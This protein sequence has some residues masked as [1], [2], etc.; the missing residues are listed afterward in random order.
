MVRYGDMQV[1]SLPL[2]G[3]VD[4]IAP[5][6]KVVVNRAVE[7]ENFRLTKDGSRIQKR[8]GLTEEVTNFAVDLFGYTT[9]LNA[10]DTF[11]ELAVLET[12]VNRKVGAGAWGQIY[13]FVVGGTPTNIAHPVIPIEIQGKEFVITEIDSRMVHYD[14]SNYQIGITA[15]TGDGAQTLPVCSL[16]YSTVETPPLNDTMNY[17]D[18]AAM[19]AVWTNADSGGTSTYD[20]SDPDSLVGPDADSKYMRLY[21]PA[22]TVNAYA[23]RTL[24]TSTHV[25]Q[26]W[27]LDTSLYFDSLGGL[28]DM[29]YF[30]IVVFTGIHKVVFRWGQTGCWLYGLDGYHVRVTSDVY[31][32]RW[33]N[34]RFVVDGSLGGNVEIDAY[35]NDTWQGHYLYFNPTTDTPSFVQATIQSGGLLMIN[36]MDVHV[37]HI[38]IVNKTA[39]AKVLE[40]EYR[41]AVTYYRGGNFPAESNPIKSHIGDV[42]FTGAGTNDMTVSGSYTGTATKTFRIKVYTGNAGGGVK[43]ILQWSE[44]DGVTWFAKVACCT[45]T[46]IG[47]GLTL[48]FAT[49]TT[50]HT[51]NDYWKFICYV[52]AGMPT[53]QEVTLSALP[54]SSDSQVSAR[55]IYRTR[56]NGS[57]FYYLCTINDNTTTT[58]TDNMP[59]SYLGA[60]MEEDHDRFTSG[61]STGKFSAYWEDRLWV[62]GDNIVYYSQTRYPEHFD[63]DTRYILVQKG[64]PNDEITGLKPY[65]DSLYV[66]TKKSIYA[67]QKTVLGY[68]CYL[69]CQDIGCRAP[70]SIIEV[71]STLMFVSD[72]GIEV[73]NGV[74]VYP[75]CPSDVIERTIGT[76]DTTKYNLITSVHHKQHYEVWFSIPD[77][78]GGA[79]AI[80]IVYHYPTNEFYFFSFYKTPSCLA[81]VFDANGKRVTKLGT[82]DGYLC[83]TESTYRDNTTAITAKYRKGWLSALAYEDWRRMEVEYE[84][85]SGMTL[86]SN[87]Y[88]NFDKDVVRTD[89]HTG[90][91]LNSDDI[92]LRRPIFD[93]SELGQRAKYFSLEFT[94]AENLGGELKIND[95][96]VYH[97][98]RAHKGKIVGD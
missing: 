51:T 14:G 5:S 47:Y 91:S 98:D 75:I 61:E 37:D 24:T 38:K 40:G 81:S 35:L 84:I 97:K 2:T 1:T 67:I 50:A 20:T 54:V 21:V 77:R 19:D 88:V 11:C 78:T 76:I 44:D 48:A 79:S 34:W 30:E 56:K 55:K 42:S 62:S 43:D 31:T 80:T 26:I 25:G 22:L 52:C 72:R 10:S 63:I 7:M 16:T 53:I 12:G 86:T 36:T 39:D 59:D 33:D 28:S 27:T 32:N 70:W 46:Y 69:V 64:N 87:V 18:Q 71:N 15:P 95:I 8:L 96:K 93:F 45:S 29:C 41:Y 9:Y 17:A 57:I 82:R 85:P 6:N 74:D 89:S 49:T 94:N 65:K 90:A 60:E 4:E 3:G 58:M 23:R 13:A 83:L 68:G 92:E 66:F 73:F